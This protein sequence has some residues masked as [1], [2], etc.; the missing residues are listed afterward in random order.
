METDTFYAESPAAM[1]GLPEDTR[2]IQYKAT[3]LSPR[4]ANAPVLESVRV[5]Y[6]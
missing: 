5:E 3:L 6:R 4:G 1:K 2:W